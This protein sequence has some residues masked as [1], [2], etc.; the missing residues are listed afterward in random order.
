M[1]H[2][3][4]PSA[5]GV[6]APTTPEL[7]APHPSP[8]HG[9]PTAPPTIRTR[10]LTRRFG[11]HTALSNVD[12]AVHAGEI[13]A[14]VGPNG[15]GKTTLLRLLTGLV[16]PT[17]GS[18]EVLGR[19]AAG[20]RKQRIRTPLGYVPSGDRTF[21]LRLS[22][23]E[24]LRFFAQMQGMRNRAARR[25]SDELLDVVGLAQVGG[26][27]VA[28]YSHGMQKRLSVARGLLVRPPVLL[29]D[30][31]THDLDPAGGARIRDMI[32]SIA[33]DGTA[34]LWAT[35]RLEELNGFADAVMV[36]VDGHVRHH[37][38][39]EDL[40]RRAPGRRFVLTLTKRPDQSELRHAAASAGRLEVLPGPHP[41]VLLDLHPDAVLGHV[42][43][44]L[45]S[46]GH[47]VVGCREE[48]SE[49]LQAFLCVTGEQPR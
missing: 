43:C 33:S 29:I 32:K 10:Q 25:R 38:P 24:N 49:I 4:R 42:I 16:K 21:Y 31:A 48:R 30:E 14:V 23:R 20:T 44:A 41:R 1:S 26:Q 45:S 27:A 8:G 9:V 12:L 6:L 17:G 46:A 19:P 36:L 13:L 34:V 37:G 5:Q 15:A 3:P 28:R 11:A 18:I 35:Q 2:L 47:E 39:F 40:L 22:G 7:R